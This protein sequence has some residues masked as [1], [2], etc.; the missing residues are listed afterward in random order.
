MLSV[1]GTGRQSQ[2]VL[3]ERLID[4]APF[5]HRLSY[6]YDVAQLKH[7][8]VF[9]TLKAG[10][11]IRKKGWIML[12][13][14]RAIKLFAF[15][16]T[17]MALLA[18]LVPVSARA[19][20]RQWHVEDACEWSMLD[21]HLIIRPANGKESAVYYGNYGWDQRVQ[22]ATSLSFEGRVEYSMGQDLFYGMDKLEEADLS[23]LFYDGDNR[24]PQQR[25]I[26]LQECASLEKII[27]NDTFRGYIGPEIHDYRFTPLISYFPDGYWMP[28]GASIPLPQSQIPD[29]KAN[30]YTL[31][32][33]EPAEDTW[34]AA[35]SIKW[36]Y[37]DGKLAIK[38]LDPAMTNTVNSSVKDYQMM[39]AESPWLPFKDKIRSVSVED[40]ITAT[41]GWIERRIL[42][43]RS[44]MN[45]K[46]VDLHKVGIETLAY[47]DSISCHVNDSIATI[48]LGS[49]F[50]VIRDNG[51]RWLELR[52]GYW[53]SGNNGDFF[54]HD[55]M[56]NKAADTYT[57]AGTDPK[58]NCWI[59]NNTAVWGLFDGQ[60]TVKPAEGLDEGSFGDGCSFSPLWGKLA[61][62]IT[63]A[64]IEKKVHINPQGLF[65]DCI[66]LKT[67][68]LRGLDI[69]GEKSMDGMFCGCVSLKTVDLSS[70]DVGDVESI[71]RM[72][73][74]AT[75]LKSFSFEKM[76]FL[77]LCNLSS[78]FSNCEN[79]TTV[80]L[81]GLQSC[82]PTDISGMF[83]GCVKLKSI[84][85][86]ESLDVS[87]VT[88]MRR[89]FDSCQELRE[90]NL[91]GWDTSAATD[92]NGMFQFCDSLRSLD[93]S[94]F[95]TR[96]VV[97]LGWFLPEWS[98]SFVT[99]TVG[100]NFSFK[101]YSSDIN[102]VLMPQDSQWK[103]ST[104]GKT[105]N[106]DAMPSCV[107][108][109]Y[110]RVQ[111]ASESSGFWDVDTSNPH[112]SSISWLSASGIS[113]GFP[114]GGFHPMANVVRQD[115]AAFLYRLCGEPD[116]TPSS[117][118]K[119]RFSDVTEA[120]PHAKE[121]WWLAST[122]ISTGYPDGTFRPVAAVVRQDMAAFLHRTYVKFGIGNDK[123][124]GA[125]FP[126]VGSNTPHAVDI[127]WLAANG[128]SAGYP[129]GTFRPMVNVVRQDM[130]AFLKRIH[131][132]GV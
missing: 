51:S 12:E 110:S 13:R 47:A 107:A 105:Y 29:A 15:F 7:G 43:D 109:T 50:S 99:F 122:G 35:E 69:S 10:A 48:S 73:Y 25:A 55:R 9:D 14:K 21:G 26:H 70:L 4:I 114:D 95:D 22:E 78:T 86:L 18:C 38:R 126:D 98:K 17:M 71:S 32:S 104:D 124:A 2:D 60:L 74:G 58:P 90:V 56:P 37:S 116:Y 96:N 65:K 3:S 72:F 125:G 59:H 88:T 27:T 132:L 127:R 91:S 42:A 57:F 79:M 53:Q 20:E 40:K 77:N 84:E 66:R 97:D 75:Q 106:W 5:A 113:T 8:C 52:R 30:T 16:G 100:P 118:D 81:E 108:A 83:E 121:I 89:L 117:A 44:L 82:A 36:K 49:S 31:V 111:K 87:N 11:A 93:L 101:G 64:K 115:M 41:E 85:G 92:M 119:L 34:Y 6:A 39:G 68:D 129:D 23:N 76:G 63:S 24:L 45:L 19:V 94:S 54:E 61:H 130:A 33:R 1:S 131:D 67:V 102:Q 62:Q 80:S 46:S 28:E 128:I 112:F 103:S 120:T 123:P